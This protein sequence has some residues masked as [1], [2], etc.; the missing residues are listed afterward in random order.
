MAVVKSLKSA[1]AP[2]QTKFD[3]EELSLVGLNLQATI[4][5][6][7]LPSNLVNQLSSISDKLDH[8]CQLILIGHAGRLLWQKVK[9][10]QESKPSDAKSQHPIDDFS[11][12]HVEDFFAQRFSSDDFELIFPLSDEN[13]THIGLQTLG[14]MAGWHN[15]S[16]FA[17]GINQQWGSWF[18][19]RA[20]V[21]IKSDYLSS[22]VA[23]SP[24]PCL[25]CT[26]HICV[27]SCPA[28]ALVGN[29]LDLDRCISY[30]KVPDSRCKDRC[31]ARMSCPVA[32]KH[33]Y[34][35]EQIQYHYG[36]SLQTIEYYQSKR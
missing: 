30:R 14:E 32:G 10:W 20:V 6:K 8:Y 19:Y 31:I 22:E 27:Q 21:L 25:S 24:S 28:D 16:P 35:L 3:S 13:Q 26:H 4:N 17:V 15:T 33:Q 18:A 7:Q 23:S 34:I 36:R 1:V 12:I 5:L 29:K 11:R 9:A 2:N